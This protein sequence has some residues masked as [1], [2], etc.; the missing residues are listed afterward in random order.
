MDK[1]HLQ[2]SVSWLCLL[3]VS[4]RMFSGFVLFRYCC[5]QM[6]A[7]CSGGKCDRQQQTTL[8]QGKMDCIY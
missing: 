5:V 8:A 6:S 1:I 7:F 4:L 3:Q 2:N